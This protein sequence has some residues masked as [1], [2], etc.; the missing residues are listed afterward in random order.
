MKE[1]FGNAFK[2]LSDLLLSLEDQIKLNQN[3]FNYK[4]K[5]FSK[6]TTEIY[7][8]IRWDS[9]PRGL[10]LRHIPIYSRIRI[11]TIVLFNCSSEKCFLTMC[12]TFCF[13]VIVGVPGMNLQRSPW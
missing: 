5:T 12:Y 11:I 10:F 2:T 6:F 9:F 7:G 1:Q 4:I 3:E 8:D 13:I